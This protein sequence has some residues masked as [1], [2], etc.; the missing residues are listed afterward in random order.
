M[1]KRLWQLVALT[2][3]GLT[4]A[5]I[6]GFAA[7]SALGCTGEWKS[8]QSCFYAGRDVA[9][10]VFGLQFW[11]IFVLFYMCLPVVIVLVAV[12]FGRAVL[13]PRKR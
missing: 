6:V 11:P 4:L 1:L 13:K 5:A 8:Y 10:F 3:L 9:S 7:Q 2:V 12:V